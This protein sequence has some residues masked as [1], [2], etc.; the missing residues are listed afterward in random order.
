MKYARN[1]RA[2][3]LKSTYGITEEKY[4]E[5]L[6]SQ[7]GC[8]AVCKRHYKNFKV[9]LAVDHDHKTREIF[10]LLCT[11]CNHRFI[12]RDRDPNRYLAAA[13][14]LSKGTGL[15]VPEKKSKKSKRK[16]KSKR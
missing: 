15:F 2:G 13:E 8:C 12:G 5:L 1:N 14:Y 16:T 4:E 7:K 11:Y 9:R 6:K 3:K 10:G